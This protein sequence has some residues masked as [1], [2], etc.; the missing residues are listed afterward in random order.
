MEF[1]SQKVIEQYQKNNEKSYNFL[2]RAVEIM[3]ILLNRNYD[4]FIIGSAVRN[5]YLNKQID[6]IEIVTIATFEQIKSIFPS[7]ITEKNGLI[8]L[9]EH[10]KFI[11]F[12]KFS[13]EENNIAK[14]FSLR[15]YN[16]KL[17]VTLC[18][19]YYTVNSLALTPNLVIT[20]IFDGIMDLDDMVVKTIDKPKNLYPKHP[21]AIMEALILVAENNFTIDPK[22]LKSI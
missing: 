12:S 10:G 11:V 17:I 15:H 2:L 13:E 19:K 16:K 18:S 14:K 21:I 22:C 3:K 4:S 5:L 6:T 7:V 8:Y 9:K 20:N 1:Q